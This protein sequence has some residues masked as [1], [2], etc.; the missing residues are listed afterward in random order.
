MGD[1]I[2]KLPVDEVLDY[3]QQDITNLKRFFDTSISK[4]NGNDTQKDKNVYMFVGLITLLFFI[5][6][7][8]SGITKFLPETYKLVGSSVIFGILLYLYLVFNK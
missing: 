1:L 6:S 3:S 4:K 8:P 5:C 7:H 2:E